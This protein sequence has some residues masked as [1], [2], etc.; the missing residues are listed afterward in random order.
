MGPIAAHIARGR[1]GLCGGGGLADPQPSPVHLLRV[2]RAASFSRREGWHPK[3]PS[4]G[5]SF[6]CSLEKRVI[7]C[8]CSLRSRGGPVT[9]RKRLVNLEAE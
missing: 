3:V 9:L 4:I 1:G 5:G 6:Q 2:C 7:S 8:D